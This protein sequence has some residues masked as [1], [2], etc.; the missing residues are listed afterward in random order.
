MSVISTTRATERLSRKLQRAGLNYWIGRSSGDKWGKYLV[1]VVG[2]KCVAGAGWTL[3]QAEAKVD[4]MI[5]WKDDPDAPPLLD[6][7]G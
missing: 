1:F 4:H 2:G 6:F 3:Q 7:Q 5:A